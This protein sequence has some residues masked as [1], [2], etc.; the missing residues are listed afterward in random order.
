M[1]VL[2]KLSS[3][4][5]IILT[6]MRAELGKIEAKYKK[7]N[8]ERADVESRFP[9]TEDTVLATKFAELVRE[10]FRQ[11][12]EVGLTYLQDKVNI[13][14]TTGSSNTGTT[15]NKETLM[16]LKFSGDEKTAYLKYPVWWKQ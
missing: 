11:C 5:S 3:D 15:T 8:A 1:E 9:S 16:L 2:A 12:K 7:L 13:R 10:V 4:K 14:Y 6:D